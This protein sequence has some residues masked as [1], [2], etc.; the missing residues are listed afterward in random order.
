MSSGLADAPL[1]GSGHHNLD[2]S[3]SLED[4]GAEKCGHNKEK[5]QTYI[6]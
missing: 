2:N 5:E 3:N 1:D 6:S 4:L